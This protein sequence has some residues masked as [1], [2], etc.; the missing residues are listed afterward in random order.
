MSSEG[1]MTKQRSLAVWCKI[2][3]IKRDLTKLAV[4]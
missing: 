1:F 4:P 3:L 2:G